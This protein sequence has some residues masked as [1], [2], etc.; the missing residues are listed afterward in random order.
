MKAYSYIRFSTPDQL[1]GDSLRRQLE[2]SEKYCKA[3]GLILDTTLNL[4]DLGLSAFHGEHK[5]KGALGQF[6]KLIEAN[7]IEP[8]SILIVESLDRLS[9][10]QVLEALNQFT[11]IIQAGVKIVTLSDKQ[12]YSKESIAQ[13]WTQLI[14]SISEMARANSESVM[15]SKRLKAAWEAKRENNEVKMTNKIPSWLTLSKDRKTFMLIPEA[16]QAI[17]LIYKLKLKG[18]GAER[19]AMELNQKGVWSPPL[20]GRN[21]TGGGWRKSYVNKLLWNN[22]ALIGE[23]QP[24]ILVKKGVREPIGEVIKDYYPA[25]IDRDLFNAVQNLIQS[26]VVNGQNHKGGKT[27]KVSNLFSYIAKCGLC[28]SPMHFVDK[29]NPPKGRTYLHCDRSRRK[30][31]PACNA[32]A[33]RYDEFAEIVFNELED[34]DI[35]EMLPGE[36]QRR[37]ALNELNIQIASKQYNLQEFDQ[38]QQNLLQRIKTTSSLELQDIYENSLLD[39]RQ[40][41]KKTRQE[42]EELNN[43]LKELNTNGQILIEGINQVKDYYK[44]LQAIESAHLAVEMRLKLRTKLQQV[45]KR[46]DVYPLMEKYVAAKEV[47][48]GVVEFMHSKHIDFIRIVFNGGYGKTLKRIIYLK[49]CGEEIL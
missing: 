23:F 33:I 46:I 31:Q 21:K 47:E 29:G 39:V 14:L 48:P 43:Q 5:T 44:Q 25:A 30:L 17:E 2:A 49:S 37:E 36:E 1:K 3:N 12:E 24:H 7:K 10:Q 22:T 11:T 16:A 40:Q 42:I 32:K 26:K 6:I 41:A 8:D 34:L 18:Y 38:Q 28:G 15:K 20:S 13:N 9:R 19:I 27:G 45:I 35:T 4:K